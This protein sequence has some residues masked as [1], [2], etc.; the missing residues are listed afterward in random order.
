MLWV[1]GKMKIKTM[2]IFGA[3]IISTELITFDLVKISGTTEF[4]ET[5]KLGKSFL[6]YQ[7]L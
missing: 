6:L 1:Q 5:L 3:V 7:N 4:M 2:P